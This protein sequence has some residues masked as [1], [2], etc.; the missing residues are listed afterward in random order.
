VNNVTLGIFSSHTSYSHDRSVQDLA[1]HCRLLLYDRPKHKLVYRWLVLYP[2]YVMCEIAI[3]STD[4]AELL[5]SAIALCMLFPRLPLWT[6]V[7]I[8]ACDVFLILGFRDPLGGR[9]AKVFEFL[10]AALVRKNV[11]SLGVSCSQCYCIIGPC[12]PRMFDVSDIEIRYRLGKRFWW[13]HSL[14][15]NVCTRRSLYM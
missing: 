10:I 5:G 7:L 8:T 9:P 4:L 13:I 6:G 3:I 12:G 15:G 2:L 1:S 11:V 14:E